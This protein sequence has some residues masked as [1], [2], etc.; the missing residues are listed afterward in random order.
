MSH[1]KYVLDFLWTSMPTGNRVVS[2]IPGERI[3]KVS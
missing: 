3:K 1:G 2:T